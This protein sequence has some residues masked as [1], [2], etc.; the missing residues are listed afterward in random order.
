MGTIQ[1]AL[2]RLEWWIKDKNWMGWDPFD[3]LSSPFLYKLSFGN[4]LVGIVFTQLLKRSPWNFRKLLGINQQINAKGAGL[5]LQANLRLYAQ[6]A[7]EGRLRDIHFLSSWIEKSLVKGDFGIGWGYYFPW[8]N[9]DFF[10]PASTPYAV[11]TCYVVLAL[12]E[13]NRLSERHP[14]ILSE[15]L[16]AP[17]DYAIGAG[18]FILEGLNRFSPSIDEACFSYS[19]VDQRYLHNINLLCARLLAELYT[20]TGKKHYKD[21]VLKSVRYTL[22]RQGPD[23]E[24]FYGEA[25]I[26]QFIDNIHAGFILVAL[27]RIG[28]ILEIQDLENA[29]RRGYEYWK[30]S[31]FT[32]QGLPKYHSDRI[33]PVDTHAIA[34]SI[35]TFVEFSSR[36]P[37][38][39]DRAMELAIWAIESMQDPGGYFYYQKYPRYTIRIPYMRWSQAW[40]Y[41]AL[42]GLLGSGW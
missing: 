41:N 18:Q 12:L 28:E 34:Q 3:A 39:L 13:M 22:N 27:N 29:L 2:D 4:N 17:L 37:L 6:R 40:M 1:E 8:A 10:A 33:Y 42:T 23:G 26:E 14:E 38:A 31:L 32:P 16:K 24:W 21:A 11:V 25:K 15:L 20:S 7:N 36:D 30:R 5:L 35:L 9:R 19:T